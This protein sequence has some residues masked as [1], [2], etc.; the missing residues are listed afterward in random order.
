MVSFLDFDKTA[1]FTEVEGSDGVD[2]LDSHCQPLSNEE[3]AE[4][5][6]LTMEGIRDGGGGGDDDDDD[7]EVEIHNYYIKWPTR[8]F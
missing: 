2:L 8:S 1:S 3:L 4:L 5:D 7:D 6:Q